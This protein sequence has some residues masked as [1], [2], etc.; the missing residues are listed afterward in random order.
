MAIT[1][2]KTARGVAII[3]TVVA[4]VVDTR[5]INK[6]TGTHR[7]QDSGTSMAYDGLGY[8]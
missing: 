1:R 8:V 5:D 7:G 2:D 3:T 6:L 4:A